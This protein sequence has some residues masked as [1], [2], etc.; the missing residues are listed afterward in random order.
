M[1]RP[2]KLHTGSDPNIFLMPFWCDIHRDDSSTELWIDFHQIWSY[3]GLFYEIRN[4]GELG[5]LMPRINQAL[6]AEIDSAKNIVLYDWYHGQDQIPDHQ[7]EWVR[8]LNNYRPVTWITLNPKPIPGVHTIHFDYYWNRSKLVF[9]DK[10]AF[11][12]TYLVENFKQ[13]DIHSRLRQK[14]YLTYHSRPEKFRDKVRNHLVAHYDGFYNDPEAGMWL[15]PDVPNFGEYSPDHVSPPGRIYYDESYVTCLVETQHQGSNS[16]LISE[17]TY[18]NMLQGRGVLN[19]ATPGFYQQLSADGW[20]LPCGI[21]WTWD[22]IVDDHQRLAAYLKE[23]DKLF[24][25]SINQLH[26]WHM[27][28]IECWQYNQRMLRTKKYDIINLDLIK[29]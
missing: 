3:S 15:L 14:K 4:G 27:S 17:K 16:H 28:N 18:D 25:C 6:Q 29:Q 20:L 8:N 5:K 23:L 11:H 10:L 9:L 24:D 1:S 2:V 26:D 22:N 7:I 21:D 13:Y 19:F 12:K